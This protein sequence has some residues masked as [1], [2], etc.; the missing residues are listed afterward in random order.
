VGAWNRTHVSPALSLSAPPPLLTPT[1]LSSAKP[2]N[3]RILSAK[4]SEDNNTQTCAGWVISGTSMATPVVAG[5]AVLVR[6]YF[7]QVR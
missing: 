3:R 1:A 5:T 6:D 2:R 7:T 4:P